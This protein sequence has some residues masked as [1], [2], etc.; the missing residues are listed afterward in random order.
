MEET[1]PCLTRDWILVQFG[2]RRRRAEG[3]Y[4]D[5]VYDGI[6]GETIWKEIKGQSLLGSEE[7]V[8]RLI[9]YPESGV[10]TMV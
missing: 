7:F 9:N 8:D 6:G 4:R 5:F 10:K 1:H 2:V 3:R